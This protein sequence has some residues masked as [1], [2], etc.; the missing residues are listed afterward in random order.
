MC[1]LSAATRRDTSSAEISAPLHCHI[2]ASVCALGQRFSS[3]GTEKMSITGAMLRM[4]GVIRRMRLLSVLALLKEQGVVSA[5]ACETVREK[6][7]EMMNFFAHTG[8]A[9]AGNRSNSNRIAPTLGR[10][11]IPQAAQIFKLQTANVGGSRGTPL[12][13]AWGYK[14]ASSH[15]RNA[16]SSA[17]PQ[18]EN[19]SVPPCAA[20]PFH[21]MIFSQKK[22]K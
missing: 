14:G 2:P 17:R 1:S 4:S 15:A 11:S 9:A 3:M 8:R 10:H 18:G 22:R 6:N 13:F 7:S 16:P 19:L 5:D 12:A 21:A 20:S